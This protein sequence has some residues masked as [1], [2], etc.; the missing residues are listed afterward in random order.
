M[1]VKVYNGTMHHSV[2]ITPYQ[3]TLSLQYNSM[4]IQLYYNNYNAENWSLSG[5]WDF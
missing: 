4:I 3:L 5:F 1:I 2:I